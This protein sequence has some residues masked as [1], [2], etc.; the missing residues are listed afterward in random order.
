MIIVFSKSYF[1][2][3]LDKT[4]YFDFFLSLLEKASQKNALEN[5]PMLNDYYPGIFC[6]NICNI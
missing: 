3:H 6:L 5:L 2:C 1:S 4:S